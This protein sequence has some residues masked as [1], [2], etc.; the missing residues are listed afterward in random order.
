MV[1]LKRMTKEKSASFCVVVLFNVC[2]HHFTLKNRFGMLNTCQLPTATP[3]FGEAFGQGQSWPIRTL[4]L[5]QC[6]VNQRVD[7]W[8]F[9]LNLS[10]H[11]T[12]GILRDLRCQKCP[13][14]KQVKKYGRIHMNPRCLLMGDNPSGFFG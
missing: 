10:Q 6:S 5:F 9:K 13:I 7:H 11:G 14:F 12:S 2:R 1:L 8:V 3:H 4:I